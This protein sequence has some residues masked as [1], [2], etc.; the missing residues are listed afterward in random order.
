ML[1][2]RTMVERVRA[3]ARQWHL[4]VREE[5]LNRLQTAI[6]N[7]DH[8]SQ[9]M[10]AKA[11]ELYTSAE[12]RANGTIKQAEKLAMHVRVI[13]E[14]EQAVDELE[15]KLQEWEAL[16]DLRLER[17]LASLATHESSLESRGCSRDRAKGF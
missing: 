3:E 15:Q 1:K 13:E 11:K 9:K 10:L 6:N 8:D 5:L 4:D 12:A 17:E 16:D 7:H 14:R 2:E